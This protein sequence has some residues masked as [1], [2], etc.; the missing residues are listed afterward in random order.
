MNLSRL[1]FE[2]LIKFTTERKIRQ[3]FKK[4]DEAESLSFSFSF[5]AANKFGASLK[6]RNVKIEIKFCRKIKLG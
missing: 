4:K 3:H 6:K 2:L 5:L 1:L